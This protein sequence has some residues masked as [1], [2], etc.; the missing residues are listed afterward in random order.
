MDVAPCCHQQP[1]DKSVAP[2]RSAQ[3]ALATAAA[4]SLL[5][6]AETGHSAC[7]CSPCHILVA[8]VL[9][10]LAFRSAAVAARSSTSHVL[11]RDLGV[12]R[13]SGRV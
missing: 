4:Q 9:D 6:F 11:V 3:P 8:A 13:M 2:R 5:D 1:V 12:A 10:C 7:S